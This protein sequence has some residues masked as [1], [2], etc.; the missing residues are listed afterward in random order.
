MRKLSLAVA[1]FLPGLLW[2]FPTSP[3]M[4]MGSVSQ[5]KTSAKPGTGPSQHV[6]KSSLQ[7]SPEQ[8]TCS[9]HVSHKNKW[10]ETFSPLLLQKDAVFFRSKN[11][12]LL[13][14]V[15]R[16]GAIPPILNFAMKN[17]LTKPILA[18]WGQRGARRGE[19][20]LPCTDPAWTK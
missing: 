17:S 12:H 18:E 15:P 10:K 3:D 16:H 14:K 19:D 20:L 6:C 5:A 8:K 4:G 7:L 9:F 2:A 11:T 1:G 13:E